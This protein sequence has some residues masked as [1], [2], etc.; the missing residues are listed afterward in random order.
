M[1]RPNPQRPALQRATCA[2]LIAASFAVGPVEAES[3]SSIQRYCQSSWRQAG[4]PTHDWEDCTQETMAELLSRVPRSLLGCAIEKA[5]SSERRELMRSIWCV[6]Q[7]WRRAS[8]R[9][10]ITL[11]SVADIASRT[12]GIEDSLARSEVIRNGL[13]ELSDSQ[14]RVLVLWSNGYSI[15]D[16]SDQLEISPARVSDHKYKAIHALRK[17]VQAEVS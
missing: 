8:Q 14:R 2:A 6:T 7:R 1:H 4:I 17:T 11:E 10:A 3:I 9:Q 5:K 15:G 12:A 16:I 13:N